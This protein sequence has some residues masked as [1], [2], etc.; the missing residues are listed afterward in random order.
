MFHERRFLDNVRQL[1]DDNVFHVQRPVP[2]VSGR[3]RNHRPSA[4]QRFV[5]GRL[6]VTSSLI[7][8]RDAH[9]IQSDKNYKLHCYNELINHIRDNQKIMKKYDEFFDVMGFGILFQ[10][11]SGSYTVITLIFLTSLTYL[12]G[13]SLLSEPVLKAFFGFLSITFQLFLYCYVFNHLETGKS[14]VNFGLYSS[15]WTAMDLKFKKILLMAMSMN[16][17]HRRAMKVSQK[18]IVNLEMF[19]NIMNMSYSIVSVLLNS[20][21]TK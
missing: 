2:H 12:M 20:R 9:I 10:I 7:Y 21:T 11:I 19:A 5:S 14:S 17:A 4:R 1:R 18:S 8:F 3:F 13:F 6:H 15:N 16:S